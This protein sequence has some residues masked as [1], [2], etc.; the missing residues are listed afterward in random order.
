MPGRSPSIAL[1]LALL[2]VA[3]GCGAATAQ[4]P[5]L[6]RVN[7]FPNAKAL[8]FHA[9][10]ATGIFARHGIRLDLAF[11]DN[12][13]NQREG[14]AAG[15]FDLA[16]SALDNAVAMIEV[17]RKDVIIVAGGD[18]GTNEFFV[19]NRFLYLPTEEVAGFTGQLSKAAPLMSQLAGD[20]SLRGLVS[21]MS[22]A[23]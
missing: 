3:L 9:G 10:I 22:L 12:S 2:L 11:T 17:A 4:E 23:C 6:V 19:R 7:T 21:A 13:R 14:L 16:Q 18:G 8:P 5:A 1:L 20:P 15:R